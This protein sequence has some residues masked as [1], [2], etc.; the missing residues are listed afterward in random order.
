MAGDKSKFLLLKENKAGIL[1]FGNDALGKIKGKG[2]V[3]LGNGR[4]KAQD[5]IFVDALN[6]NPLS[7]S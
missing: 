5:V 7:V 3:S 2:L 1:T 6:H 4:R